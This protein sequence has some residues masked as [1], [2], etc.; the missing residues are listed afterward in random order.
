VISILVTGA[1]GF[2]GRRVIVAARD[3]GYCVI[4]MVRKAPPSDVQNVIQHD[5]TIPLGKLLQLPRVDWIFHLAGAYAGAG[6]EEL[7]R[8]DLA[9]AHNLM[10]WGTAAGVKNWVFAS[11]AEVYGDVQ[12]TAGEDAPTQPVIPYGRIKLMVERLVAE[13]TKN[14]SN[15]RVVVLRIGEVYGSEGRLIT[16]L[17]A[18]LK[19]G[20]CPWPGKGQVPVSFVHVDDVAQAFASAIQSAPLGVS[21]YNV[22]DD[23][24]AT[25]R[26][27]L[28]AVARRLSAGPPVFLPTAVVRFYATYSTLAARAMRREPILT[29]QALRLIT[30]PKALSNIRLKD[31]LGFRPHYRRYS[32]GLEEALRGV[33]HHT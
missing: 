27:F 28:V 17:T 32:E 31:E 33:P 13:K 25:W 4:P 1:G 19:R 3:A 15:C 20:F 22:A 21:I 10:D 26:D 5:L 29:G 2:I 16:E 11:A 9:M 7:R 12:G 24:P 8:A 23:M 6:Y 18:R 30:T 14:I